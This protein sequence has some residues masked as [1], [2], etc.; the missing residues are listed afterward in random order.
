[1][2]SAFINA[3]GKRIRVSALDY[4]M[5]DLVKTKSAASKGERM[6]FNTLSPDGQRGLC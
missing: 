6:D 5:Q 2:N 4:M 1:M 3:D